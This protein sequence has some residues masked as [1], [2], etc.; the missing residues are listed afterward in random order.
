MTLI[1]AKFDTDLINISEVTSRKTNGPGFFGLPCVCPRQNVNV[2]S[3]CANYPFLFTLVLSVTAVIFQFQC[4]H[5]D[6]VPPHLQERNTK[7]EGAGRAPE[8]VPPTSNPR[9]RP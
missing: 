3:V 8:F 1:G 7:L 4:S 9:R 5:C 2:R 6:A